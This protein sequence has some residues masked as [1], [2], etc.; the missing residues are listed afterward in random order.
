MPSN[1]EWDVN[2]TIHQSVVDNNNN[3]TYYNQY[4]HAKS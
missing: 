2:Q 3:N 1:D 4:A